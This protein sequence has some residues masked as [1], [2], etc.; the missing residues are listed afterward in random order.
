VNR[1]VEDSEN[2]ITNM[3][4]CIHSS[5]IEDLMKQFANIFNLLVFKEKKGQK[6]KAAH[7]EEILTNGVFLIILNNKEIEDATS[8]SEEDKDKMPIVIERDIQE[9]KDTETMY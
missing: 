2:N 8:F 3:S 5:T 4:G 6:C 7:K 1:H 9:F